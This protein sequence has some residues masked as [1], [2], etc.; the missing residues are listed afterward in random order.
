MGRKQTRDPQLAIEW[1]EAMRWE[2]LPP[3]V[4]E[5]VREQ[6]AALLQATARRPDSEAGEPGDDE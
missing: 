1:T 5:R 2:E 4:R 3:V 6:L